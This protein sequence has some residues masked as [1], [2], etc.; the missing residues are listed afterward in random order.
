MKNT[1]KIKLQLEAQPFEFKLLALACS[2]NDYTLSWLINK[3]L[4]VELKKTSPLE[5]LDSKLNLECKFERFYFFDTRKE[6]QY[7]LISNKTENGYLV[8]EQSPIDFFFKIE[9]IDSEELVALRKKL[10]EI[11]EIRAIFE[12]NPEMLKSKNNFIF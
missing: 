3:Y 5:I 6:I 11:K 12:I 8:K 10:K 2:E 7:T 1:K 4:D 9:S